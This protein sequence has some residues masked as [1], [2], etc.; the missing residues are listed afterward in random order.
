MPVDMTALAADLA[1]ESE[2]FRAELATAGQEIDPDALGVTREPTAR[3]RHIAHLGVLTRGFSF[4]DLDVCAT[5]PST[6][7]WLTIAQAFA[8]AP[9]PGQ[10]PARQAAD[11]QSKG[12]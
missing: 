10:P 9:G 5:G 8:G 4:D 2:H 1:A 3:L 7:S 12:T 11:T 6:Q